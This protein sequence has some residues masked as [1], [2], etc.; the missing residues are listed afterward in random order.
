M[1]LLAGLTMTW[2]YD[3]IDD[4]L[5]L[6]EIPPRRVAGSEDIV[7]GTDSPVARLVV[8]RFVGIVMSSFHANAWASV[9]RGGV[10]SA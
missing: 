8:E 3:D 5:G 1:R 4:L 9:S 2:P 6:A 10:A 7:C